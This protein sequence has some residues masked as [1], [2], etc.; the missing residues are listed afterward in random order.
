MI[1]L[2]L[3]FVENVM[4][5][6]CLIFHFFNLF[7]QILVIF[8]FLYQLDIY[9]FLFF[10]FFTKLFSKTFNSSLKL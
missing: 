1:Y 9:I 4:I 6:F 3:F 10:L 5:E 8:I 2:N 7:L